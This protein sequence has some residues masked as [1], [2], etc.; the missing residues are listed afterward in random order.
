MINWTRGLLRLWLL[1]S[2]LWAVPV[3]W[4]TWPGDAPQD[5][6]RY[7]YYLVAHPEVREERRDNEAAAAK[8]RDTALAAVRGRYDGTRKP[9]VAPDPP[10]EGTR[11]ELDALLFNKLY[12]YGREKWVI[13]KEELDEAEKVLRDLPPQ[14]ESEQLQEFTELEGRLDWNE[15]R[16]RWWAAYTLAPPIAVLI[17]GASLLWALRGFRQTP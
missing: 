7:W 6:V 14:P 4:L 17:V 11:D 2:L 5:Y 8:Q 15:E 16:V 10:R 12:H 3:G 9:F 13:T 1:G